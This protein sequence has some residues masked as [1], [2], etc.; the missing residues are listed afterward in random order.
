MASA[1]VQ[2]KSD[3]LVARLTPED[4]TLLERAAV[5]EGC[6]VGRF[7]VSHSRA[8]A[9]KMV[10][11]RETIRLNA[12]ESRHFVQALLAPPRP[13]TR[14]FKEALALYRET[15]TES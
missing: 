1:P 11:E 12:E 6:S 3:R 7:V 4:K 2:R 15:V 13:P 5:L 8:A 10:Q 9:E 14:R